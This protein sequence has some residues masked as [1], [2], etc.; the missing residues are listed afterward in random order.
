MYVSKHFTMS[1][2]SISDVG[3]DHFN[4]V[5]FG[6]F[7][8]SL[9]GKSLE[10]IKE[11]NAKLPDFKFRDGDI[12]LASYPKT[13]C[14]W[15]YEILTM[16]LAGR[17]VKPDHGKMDSMLEANLPAD[18]DRQ[19]SPRVLNSHLPHHRVPVDIR[20]KKVKVVFV[21]RNPKD[22]AVSYFNMMVGM[23]HY[24]YSGNFQNWLPLYMNGPLAFIPYTD[25][26][27]EWEQVYRD[28]LYDMIIVYFEDMKKNTMHEVKRLADFLGV[29]YADELLEEIS[30]KCQFKEMQNR[31][32]KDMMGKYK[33][34][35]NYG[36]LRKGEVGD[37]K[38]WFTVAMSEEYD[39]H[40][41]QHLAGSMFQFK[42]AL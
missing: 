24:N 21:L 22:A 27:Q 10:C 35:V 28:Q 8:S 2:M 7:K 6:E 25:Y 20:N 31:Y 30:G 17:A 33:D 37:W 5:D 1:V 40:L 34:E 41:Q 42:Y 4:I 26:L 19:P 3:G 23:K 36:F 38:R 12:L 18:I 39:A 13:G 9:F 29:S 14:A 15:T 32:D 11:L 16:L